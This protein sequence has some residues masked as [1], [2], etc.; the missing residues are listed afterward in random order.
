MIQRL[1]VCLVFTY[2]LCCSLFARAPNTTVPSH[3]PRIVSSGE[4]TLW[5]ESMGEF[6]GNN[7]IIFI[8]GLGE[9]VD[10]GLIVS[11]NRLS[12]QA[13]LLFATTIGM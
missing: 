7:A 4:L 9:A 2:L 1:C 11:V 5:T 3:P 6:T 12:M 10:F 13:T 8:A